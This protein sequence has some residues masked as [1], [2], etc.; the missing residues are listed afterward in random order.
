VTM[1]GLLVTRRKVVDR[2]QLHGASSAS[3]FRGALQ[4]DVLQSR[5]RSRR[6]AGRGSCFFGPPPVP[7]ADAA[8]AVVFGFSFFG[9]LASRFPFGIPKHSKRDKSALK[10]RDHMAKRKPPLPANSRAGHSKP[11]KRAAV[12]GSEEQT[13]SGGPGC[14]SGLSKGKRNTNGLPF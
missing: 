9:F 11:S 8:A 6:A 12:A 3:S 7:L 13:T 14:A 2:S 1:A 5:A 4:T 10:P